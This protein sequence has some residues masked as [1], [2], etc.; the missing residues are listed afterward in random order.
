MPR[1]KA[2]CDNCKHDEFGDIDDP[3]N[4]CYFC[5]RDEDISKY[6]EPKEV[7]P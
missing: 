2:D 3:T 4:Q 7:K 6:W 5:V 1:M